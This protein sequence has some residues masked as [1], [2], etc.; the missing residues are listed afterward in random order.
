MITFLD[1]DYYFG[2][3]GYPITV[4]REN[5]DSPNSRPNYTEIEHY[6]NF[7]EIVVIT[8]GNG[9]HLFESKLFPV[10]TGDVF[11]IQ[12]RQRHCFYELHDLELINVLYNPKLLG[13]P[14]IQLRK[15]PGYT[16]MF[17]LEPQNRK[18]HHF[19]SKLHLKRL[20][21]AHSIQII[22]KIETAC[23]EK[24]DGW[25]VTSLTALQELII[26]LSKMYIS[27]Y[28]TDAASLIR[29]ANVIALL[30]KEYLNPLSLNDMIEIA[31]M[32]KGN[33]IRI[34]KNATHQTPNEYLIGVRLQHAIDLLCNTNLSIK[35]IAYQ[36]GFSDN[37]YFSRLFRNKIN[38]TPQ[39][40]RLKNKK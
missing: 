13:L 14:E 38:T 7:W 4:W 19:S 18:H 27:T 10:S 25:E 22:E 26:Y 8:S 30:E 24:S 12:E 33:F 39:S 6:H 21:L 2:V 20:E 36:V 29:V 28:S 35:E 34:F 11:L 37:N 1:S 31:N 23:T 40:Y 17:M 32:S 3:D 16:A 15:L 9:K 5:I